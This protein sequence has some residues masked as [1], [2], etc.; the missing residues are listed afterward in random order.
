MTTIV[1]STDT[2]PV[3]MRECPYIDEKNIRQTFYKVYQPL[4]F[5]KAY[6]FFYVGKK[7]AAYINGFDESGCRKI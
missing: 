4:N 7:Q 3:F 2:F 1:H 6:R 5:D